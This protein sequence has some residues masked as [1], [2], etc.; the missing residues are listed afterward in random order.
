MILRILCIILWEYIHDAGLNIL[1]FSNFTFSYWK[2]GSLDWVCWK[3]FLM[4]SLSSVWE[5]L[6]I[7]FSV[8]TAVKGR[9]YNAYWF[10]WDGA[11]TLKS[12]MQSALLLKKN[13][14]WIGCFVEMWSVLKW[15]LRVV[16]DDFNG[17]SQNRIKNKYYKGLH[18][19]QQPRMFCENESFL[20]SAYWLAWQQAEKLV[21]CVRGHICV[22]SINILARNYR[23][24][25]C[26]VLTLLKLS[27]PAEY[28]QTNGQ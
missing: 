4:I 17:C 22:A 6:L 7:S 12:T 18:L 24:I 26:H 8:F 2:N 23:S 11:R 15:E 28:R 27:M 14:L 16:N 13:V 3:P 9:A 19:G 25:A 21:K 20:G 5:W 10:T 1:N